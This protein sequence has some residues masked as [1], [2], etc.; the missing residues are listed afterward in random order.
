M[1]QIEALFPLAAPDQLHGRDA[2]LDV[3]QETLAA[4]TAGTCQFLLLTGESGIGKTSLAHTVASRVSATGGFFLRGKFQQHSGQR[5]LAALLDALS[6]LARQLAAG[7]PQDGQGWGKQLA[8]RLG[9]DTAALVELVPGM[10]AVC[11]PQEKPRELSPE[12]A[13]Q[14]MVDVILETLTVVTASRHC[15]VLFLDD[16]HWADPATLNVLDRLLQRGPPRVLIIGACRTDTPA[17]QLTLAELERARRS[18]A[19][20]ETTRSR[21]LSLG[22]LTS[23]DIGSILHERFGGTRDRYRGF[24]AHCE[25]HCQGNPLRLQHFL[26]V[27]HARRL[28]SFDKSTAAWSWDEK[29][30][31]RLVRAEDTIE[32]IRTRL[33]HLPLELVHLLSVA[34]CF[35]GRAVLRD[36]ATLCD[37]RPEDALRLAKQAEHERLVSFLPTELRGLRD[38]VS[39]SLVFAHDQIERA[40][41]TLP[42]E[43]TRLQTHLQIGWLLAERSRRSDILDAAGHLLFAHAL[44]RTEQER[45]SAAIVMLRATNAARRLTGWKLVRRFAVAGLELLGEHAWREHGIL[46][47]SLGRNLLEATYYARPDADLDDLLEALLNATPE[48]LQRAELHW[49]RCT[50]LLTQAKLR[51]SQQ[52]GYAALRCCLPD[53]PPIDEISGGTL[54]MLERDIDA[55]LAELPPDWLTTLPETRDASIRFVLQLLPEYLTSAFVSGNQLMRG[56]LCLIAMQTLLEHGRVAG[57]HFPLAAYAL[58]LGIRQRFSE[59]GRIAVLAAHQP[60]LDID[61]RAFAASADSLAPRALHYAWPFG[62]CHGM[63]ERANRS[64][65]RAGSPLLGIN[66]LFNALA[67][68]ISSGTPLAQNSAIIAQY[69]AES[70]RAKTAWTSATFEIF[71]NFVAALAAT[72]SAL[73]TADAFRPAECMLQSQPTAQWD[74]IAHFRLQ[75][76]FWRRERRL[77]PALLADAREHAQL[78]RGLPQMIEFHFI[79]FH[80]LLHEL[81]TAGPAEKQERMQKAFA[82][83]RHAADSCPANYAHLKTFLEA[84]LAWRRDEEDLALMLYRHAVREASLYDNLPWLALARERLAHLL[85]ARGAG[86]EARAALQLAA[87]TYRAWG[88]PQAGKTG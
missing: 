34:A 40:A 49:I 70:D 56:Y 58:F 57:N 41:Y 60:D 85:D 30:I 84:E 42:D 16:L 76:A 44:L 14:R 61:D 39:R 69:R 65:W 2:D 29:A 6:D 19:W 32:L 50:Q 25:R 75:L 12:P 80:C 82:L 20:A 59:A 71:S 74:W 28:L 62:E 7:S 72:P 36:V 13:R 1:A 47:F 51:D 86:P 22:A 27:L 66:C 48:P 26:K 78:L 64:A 43:T 18:G 33:E 83:I 4:A 37:I 10:N 55:R 73:S 17:G 46:A 35:R 5:P 67:L 8:R 9:G 3:M 87:A 15:V 63:L 38:A 24:A 88:C 79:E 68:R 81:V 52:H 54:A 45:E 77:L 23:Q 11:G 53:L 21:S 31:G